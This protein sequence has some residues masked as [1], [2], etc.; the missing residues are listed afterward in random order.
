MSTPVSPEVARALELARKKYG[1]NLEGAL[2]QPSPVKIKVTR[3]GLPEGH[4]V[5]PTIAFKH[6][7]DAKRQGFERMGIYYDAPKS[8]H[9]WFAGYDGKTIQ[10]AIESQ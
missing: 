5:H 4:A 1:P 10:E 6:G 8:D 9:F 7:Q 2:P 3:K